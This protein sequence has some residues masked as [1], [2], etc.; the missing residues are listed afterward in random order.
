MRGGHPA[1]GER[2]HDCVRRAGLAHRGASA[3]L[4]LIGINFH[5]VG[6]RVMKDRSDGNHWQAA[7]VAHRR[8]KLEDEVTKRI[9]RHS[10]LNARHTTNHITRSAA[11]AFRCVAPRR[12]VRL[13]QERT[14]RRGFLIMWP[15][16]PSTGE[17][18]PGWPDGDAGSWPRRP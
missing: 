15:A 12:R 18:L 8:W 5:Q 11:L 3:F 6:R 14:T 13:V 2:R 10:R 16:F 7:V 17:I 4:A 9:D 1:S